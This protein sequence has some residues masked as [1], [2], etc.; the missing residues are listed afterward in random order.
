MS[1]FRLHAL[2]YSFS[3]KSAAHDD[4]TRDEKD[5]IKSFRTDLPEWHDI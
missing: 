1:K 3:T 2:E 5:F 4:T